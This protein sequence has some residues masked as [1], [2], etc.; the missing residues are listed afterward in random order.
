[1]HPSLV[2]LAANFPASSGIVDS[3]SAELNTTASAGNSAYDIYSLP[4]ANSF[5]GV[6]VGATV[7]GRNIT[8]WTSFEAG[9][10]TSAFQS[11]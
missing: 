11:C 9:G 7:N 10:F 4:W 5:G 1:M 3:W 8:D 2:Y 6:S